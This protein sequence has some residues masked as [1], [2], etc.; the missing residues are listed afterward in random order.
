MNDVLF[1]FIFFTLIG[2]IKIDIW[3]IELEQVQK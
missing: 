3:T 1:I 2:L